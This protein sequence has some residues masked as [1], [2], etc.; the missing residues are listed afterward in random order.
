M[1][2]HQAP[3]TDPPEVTEFVKR[4]DAVPLTQV[5]IE[6][7]GGLLTARIEPHDLRTALGPPARMEHDG[8][9]IW[10]Y[11]LGN[12]YTG[13]VRIVDE[14]HRVGSIRVVG[15]GA[16]GDLYFVYMNGC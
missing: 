3:F 4:V 13:E 16:D 2:A 1:A 8:S 6:V 11:E 14:S 12:G 7:E 10:L 9:T 15:P 5:S